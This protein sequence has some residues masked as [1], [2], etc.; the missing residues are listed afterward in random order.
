MS[1]YERLELRFEKGRNIKEIRVEALQGEGEI[2]LTEKAISLTDGADNQESVIIPG[3]YL[4]KL[5]DERNVEFHRY[6][7]VISHNLSSN[8]L[9]KMK[10]V[11][12][13]RVI[14]ITRDF[15]SQREVMSTGNE[16][17]ATVSEFGLMVKYFKELEQALDNISKTPIEALK[18]EYQLT[19]MPKK[20]KRKRAALGSN[21][22]RTL[23][24]RKRDNSLL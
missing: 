1:E 24:R 12:E 11:L 23:P 7:E 5:V 8:Q 16:S 21:K 22:R 2:L 20:T 15:N 17:E 14:G 3:V 18:K 10:E 4:I 6:F 13:S 19:K 9:E